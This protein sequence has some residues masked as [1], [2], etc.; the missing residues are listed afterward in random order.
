MLLVT[1]RGNKQKGDRSKPLE[2][3]TKS[4][5]MINKYLINKGA[6]Y[7]AYVKLCDVPPPLKSVKITSSKKCLNILFAM[8]ILT[9]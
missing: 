2:V 9:F 8:R 4:H 3:I 5:L 7:E 1:V 6:K